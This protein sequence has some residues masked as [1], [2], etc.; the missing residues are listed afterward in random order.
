MQK[1]NFVCI[2]A[3]PDDEAFG[4][5]G[6]IH[7]LTE[8]FDVYILCATK[9]QV[10]KDSRSEALEKLSK[11]REAELRV[12]AKIIGVKNVY[13]LGFKDGTLSNNLYHKLADK[14]QAKLEELK[15]EEIMTFDQNGV[16][17]HIDHITV[18]MATTFVFQKLPNVRKIWYNC[19]SEERSQAIGKDYFIHFPKGYK[20]SQI[21]KVVDVSDVWDLKL[22]AMEAHKS[23]KH[24]MERILTRS[25]NLP[26]EEYF[27]IEN[28]S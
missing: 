8:K 16:S 9:G 4:P 6:T 21:D 18:S 20:R 3:H 24:D 2:F 23:Q 14:I 11:C 12:S 10:G 25:S 28:K 5:S 17:G 22:K 7:K 26:K 13:F 19:L 27:R 1:K 15:P